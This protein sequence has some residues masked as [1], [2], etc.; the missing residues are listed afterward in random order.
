MGII[1]GKFPSVLRRSA[2]V[3]DREIMQNG[4]EPCSR[5][6]IWP[7]LMPSADRTFERVLHE[8]VGGRS[9]AYESS[10]VTPQPG[11]DRLDELC[12]FSHRTSLSS[13]Y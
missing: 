2:K 8:I 11:N 12:H 10:G 13:R 5:I 7:A 4:E 3:I 9:I 1:Q 6:A